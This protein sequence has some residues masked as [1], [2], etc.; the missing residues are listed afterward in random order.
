MVDKKQEPWYDF[1]P[2]AVVKGGEFDYEY[3]NLI[4]T[5]ILSLIISFVASRFKLLSMSWY[6]CMTPFRYHL[7]LVINKYLCP[8]NDSFPG[9]DS[10]SNEDML[11]VLIKYTSFSLTMMFV[12]FGHNFCC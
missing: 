3:F 5:F 12:R 9:I 7:H 1:E 11:S 4:N 10:K 8:Y 2:S 6:K